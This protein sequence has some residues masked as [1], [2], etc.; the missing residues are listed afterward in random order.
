[1]STEINHENK[2][3]D[4]VS[5]QKSTEIDMQWAELAED[6]QSQPY[7]KTDIN[8]LIQKTKRRV[9]AAKCCLAL[10]VLGTIAIFIFFLVSLFSDNQNKATLY[11]LGFGS[12]FALAFCIHTVR[13]R[14]QGWRQLS[15][16]PDQAITNAIANCKSSIKYLQMSKLSCYLLLP[17]VNWYLYELA[18]SADK[19]LWPPL[20]FINIFVAVVW[21]VS[22]YLLSKRKSELIQLNGLLKE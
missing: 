2:K 5:S 20:L 3:V 7:P 21:G 17:A 19:P 11:Y 16:S 13:F 4:Q 8:K 15:D 12:I 1:M 14:I 9:I 6:W 10:D 22:H 18:T